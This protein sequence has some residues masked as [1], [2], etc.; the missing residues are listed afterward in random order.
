M[1]RV[2]L[3]TNVA[4]DFVLERIPFV[5]DAEEIFAMASEEGIQLLMSAMSFPN[6]SYIARKQYPG[7]TIYSVLKQLRQLV[8][9]VPVSIEVLD[10]ALLLEADDFEDALQYFSAISAGSDCIVT[11]NVKD[12]SFTTIPVMTPAA[13]IDMIEQNP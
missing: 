3:D 10:N 4:L 7:K 13:F 8:E 6:M 9:L 5:D 2:F 12:F 1:K 11:R